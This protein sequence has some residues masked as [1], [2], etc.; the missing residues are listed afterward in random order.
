MSVQKLQQARQAKLAEA[1]ALNE[2]YSEKPE[3]MTPETA[4]KITALLGQADELNAKI[5]LARQLDEA[6]ALDREPMGTKAAHLGWRESGPN[7]G[8]PVVDEKAYRE[9]KVGNETLR[10][11]IPE[12]VA[13]KGYADAFEAYMRK[14][15]ADLGPQDRKTLTAGSDTA[16]GFLIPED[17]HLEIIKKTAVMATIRANARVAQTSR[18]AAKWPRIVYTTDDDYTSGVRFTW[19]GESPASA[20]VHRVTDPVFGLLTIPVHTAMASMPLSNDLLEDAAFDV[21][22]IGSSLIGEAFALGENDAFINGNGVGKPMGILAQVGGAEGPASVNSGSAASL[23]SNGLIDLAY[24]LPP[25]YERN[26]KF[27]ME[28]ATEKVIRKLVGTTSG[29]YEWPVVNQVGALGTVQSALLGFPIVREQ[30]VPAVTTDSYSVIFGD[31]TGYLVLDRVGLSLQRLDELYA[32]TNI[33][34]LLARRRVGGQ[35][36][37]PWKVKVQKTST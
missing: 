20:T 4:E 33:T 25:Q 2:Q 21:Y 18:D 11:F 26:A 1:R 16:G 12:A 23:T 29:E 3:D 10:V 27:Y 5:A 31:L 8:M 28:K 37:E 15:R 19:T 7:E 36:I 13:Q 14:G 9:V 17:F 34:L 35:L 24:A 30:F 32:E 22:G 6:E